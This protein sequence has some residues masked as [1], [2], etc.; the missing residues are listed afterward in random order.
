MIGLLKGVTA[1]IGEDS[2][3]IDVH[4]VGYVIQAGAR[5]LMRLS[6]GEGVTVHVETHVREDSIRLFGFL[7]EE[8][9]AWF[10]HLQ[11][12]PSV[13]AKVALNILDALSVG[14]LVD[15]V[16][17][18]D[19][20]AIARAN[21]VGPK[22]AA[23]IAQELAGKPPP[24]GFLAMAPAPAVSRAQGAAS[25]AAPRNDAV[26]ALV[27]LGIDQSSAA[28]AVAAAMKTFEDEPPAPE[29]IRAALREVNR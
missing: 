19:K 6:V 8:E 10:T 25:I 21:G 27:N 3:L 2:A 11:S 7:S 4:G 9:R 1:A 13:G 24:R 29:L 12:V 26:S 23:R 15:A 17:L 20:A 14:E 5:T 18:E 16:A 22:L 28:R